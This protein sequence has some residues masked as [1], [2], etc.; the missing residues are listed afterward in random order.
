M[1]GDLAAIAGLCVMYGRVQ[2]TGSCN[3]TIKS[4]SYKGKKELR[5]PI[6]IRGLICGQRG[7]MLVAG[8]TGCML[9]SGGLSGSVA[10]S[11]GL[12]L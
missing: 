4:I 10:A 12:R 3:N 8:C 1:G 5:Y 9:V 2:H 6:L 7:G 11:S